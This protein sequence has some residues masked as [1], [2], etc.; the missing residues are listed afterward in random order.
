MSKGTN[1]LTGVAGEYFVA[2]ELSKR[3]YIAALTLRN[4]N[5]IDILCSD[6]KAEKQIAIQVKTSNGSKRSW[7]LSEKAEDIHS[8]TFY[9]VFVA[10]NEEGKHPDFFIVP[11]NEVAKYCKESHENW[12]NT[13]GRNGQ[14]HND[15]SI[16]NFNVEEEEKY[17]EKWDLLK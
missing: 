16:R 11:S 7:P 8:D 6:I 4:A 17:Y 15:N 14:K 12:L 3:G 5:N 1:N 10:L 13:P 9:Y 2:A